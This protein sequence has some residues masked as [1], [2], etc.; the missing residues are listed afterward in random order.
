MA[1]EQNIMTTS[2][3]LDVGCGKY[4]WTIHAPPKPKPPT[5]GDQKCHGKDD[6][7]NHKDIDKTYV[8]QGIGMGACVGSSLVN[9]RF[10]AQRLED[11]HKRGAISL[12]H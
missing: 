7:G 10:N 2:G 1:G 8:L 6:F 12:H 3:E 5:L 11:R 4:S 9:G